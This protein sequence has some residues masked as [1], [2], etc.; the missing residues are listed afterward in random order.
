MDK[1]H[2]RIGAPLLTG[3][4]LQAEGLKLD[5]STLVPAR[6]PDLHAGVPLVVMGRYSRATSFNGEPQATVKASD[7]LDQPWTHN[8]RAKASDNRA[9]TT[10]WA[11]GRV[12]D[13]EDTFA[14]RPGAELERQIVDTSLKFGVLCR[15]TAFIAVDRTQKVNEKGQ[16]RESVQPVEY[17]AGW[18]EESLELAEASYSLS[19]PAGAATLMQSIFGAAFGPV[20]GLRRPLSAST[21]RKSMAP[22][23][24]MAA[25]PPPASPA[26]MSVDSCL[27]EFEAPCDL[28]AYRARAAGWLDELT[29]LPTGDRAARVQLL[30]EL[31]RKVGELVSDL[32]SIGAPEHERA[33]LGELAAALAK[34]APTADAAEVE[35]LAKQATDV[36]SNFAQVRPAFWKQAPT[37]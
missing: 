30:R 16:L 10:I 3:V 23:A 25:P 5:H 31:A 8:L 2:R 24:A 1:I 18:E 27:Q 14:I 29:R 17:P 13:L 34:L 26:A 36:L 6:M 9:V 37:P 32:A 19:A 11:R 12:R 20:G 33:P 15:F 7:A 22:P 35:S 28:S 21:M 4:Q